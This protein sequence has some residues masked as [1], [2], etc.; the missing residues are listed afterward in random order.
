MPHKQFAARH[1][2]AAKVVVERPKISTLQE[3][4]GVRPLDDLQ[5]NGE[6]TSAA[7]VG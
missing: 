5:V 4:F 3:S 1:T 7:V 2:T 6:V